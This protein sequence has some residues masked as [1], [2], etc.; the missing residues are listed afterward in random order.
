MANT[1][2]NGVD[3]SLSGE[4]ANQ[5]IHI[6]E[7]KLTTVAQKYAL[8]VDVPFFP[9]P[10]PEDQLNSI[11]FIFAL[12]N[13]GDSSEFASI[14]RHEGRYQL[15]Y[16]RQNKRG[17]LEWIRMDDAPLD[18]RLNFL[19][20]VAKRLVEAVIA[21]RDQ[22]KQELAEIGSLGADAIKLLDEL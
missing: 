9:F 17:Q 2:P 12:M 7:Q 19:Q 21:A 13:G 5:R 8:V 14:R 11:S 20:H 10:P 3:L 1:P 6:L 18:A 22:R 16:H 15:L 4:A